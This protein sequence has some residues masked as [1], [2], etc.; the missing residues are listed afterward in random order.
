MNFS[1]K[2]FASGLLLS[3]LICMLGSFSLAIAAEKPE[4]QKG[5]D[6][7]SNYIIGPTDVLEINVWR[8]PD[9]SREVL[10]RPDGK[11]TFPLIDDIQASGMTTLELKGLITRQ[12]QNFI[13]SPEVTVIVV[14]SNSK[15]FYISGKVNAPG[16]YQLRPHMTVLQ[17]L[18]VAGGFA[19]WA[20]KDSVRIIRRTNGK[21]KIFTFN[22]DKVISGKELEQNIVLEPNDTIIVP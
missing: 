13:D 19:E 9:L 18:S 21:E 20:H 10:V 1:L 11:I 2:A 3:L 15:N 7:S 5:A 6:V 22:Y 14:Q 12:L 4:A 16:T 17:A 8:E